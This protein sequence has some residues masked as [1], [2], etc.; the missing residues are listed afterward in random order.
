[1]A[2]ASMWSDCEA[3]SVLA[4]RVILSAVYEIAGPHVRV[5]RVHIDAAVRLLYA[6]K[7]SGSVTLPS[8]LIVLPQ[9]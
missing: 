1:M 5:G 3:H 2:Y 9:L 8:N 7:P 4:S 6:Q